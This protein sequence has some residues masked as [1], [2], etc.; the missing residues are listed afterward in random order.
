MPND[1]DLHA[2]RRALGTV[3]RELT[4]WFAA[5]QR[6][7]QVAGEIARL[8]G[9]QYRLHW[10]RGY[11]EAEPYH[12]EDPRQRERGK[13]SDRKRLKELRDERRRHE[14]MTPRL[15]AA[16]RAVFDFAD[17]HGIDATPLYR[18]VYGGWER[19]R[20]EDVALLLRRVEGALDRLQ[21]EAAAAAGDAARQEPAPAGANA[22]PAEEV[23]R[24]PPPQPGE[25][26]EG[27]TPPELNDEEQP[28][29]P[30]D[31]KR[32]RPKKGDPSIN[33]K[34]LDLIDRHPEC[35]GWGSRKIAKTLGCAHSSVEAC[36]A[37]TA[38]ENL[39]RIAQAEK[40]ERDAKKR[41]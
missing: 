28:T 6:R 14:E 17:R 16:E 1:N 30:V 11:E 31:C 37:F 18:L 5:E 41:R 12:L 25:A 40:R 39:R 7:E 38:L 8:E 33:A 2:V 36:S 20:P 24:A 19:D 4:G 29:E 15:Q 22:P 26:H 34:V 3:R 13:A 9:G 21:A 27:A 10:L 35:K 32:G 23:L